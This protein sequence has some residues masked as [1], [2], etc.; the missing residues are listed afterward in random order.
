MRAPVIS[1][2]IAFAAALLLASG[3]PAAAQSWIGRGYLAIN[4]DVQLGA[5]FSGEAH[6][7]EFAEPAT[8]DASYRT[9]P[10]PG[11]DAGAGIR[12]WR[13]LGVGVDISYFTK[14]SGASVSAQVPHPFFL[15]RARTVSG[16][17]SPLHRS[18]T[19]VH[20]KAI[21]MRPVAGSA[22]WRLGLF[23][24]PSI[25]SVDQDVVTDVTVAQ[26]YPYDSATFSGTVSSRRSKSRLGFNAGIDVTYSIRRRYAIGIATSFSRAR[27]PLGSSTGERVAIDAGGAR[28]GGGLRVL[29]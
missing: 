28:V 5:G 22:R 26:S 16:D 13:D 11:I 27:V 18:E 7:I 25:I 20:V 12:V 29:F 19:G 6:P 15:G 9:K 4:G 1:R 8:I 17:A 10:A 21:W 23:G 2:T 3:I 14:S 24:G